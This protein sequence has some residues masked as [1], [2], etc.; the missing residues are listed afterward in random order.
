VPELAITKF[1]VDGGGI[2]VEETS[3]VCDGFVC[4][5]PFHGRD[6]GMGEAFNERFDGSCCHVGFGFVAGAL[7]A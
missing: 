2:D 4:W 7:V 5:E 3:D 6:D 1:G